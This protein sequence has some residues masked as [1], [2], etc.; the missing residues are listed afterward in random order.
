MEA[1]IL[2]MQID[3]QWIKDEQ[4][5]T[6]LL[7]GVNLGG[8]SKL[9]TTPDGRTFNRERFYDHRSVS[10]VGRPF[11]LSA[12]D[13]HFA[14]LRAWGMTFVRFL[15]TW[16]AVEHAGPGVYDRDYL[17]YLRAVISKAAE[18]D[19]A[20]YIDPHQD[21]WSRW[22]GGDGAP[23]WT[24][25]AIGFDLTQLDTTGA[26]I[27]HAGHGDPF[28][29]MIWPTNY[30]KLGAAT[31]FALFY[32]GDDLA[33][34]TRINGEPAQAYLQRHYIAAMQQVALALKGLPNVVGYGAMN[35]PV[36]SLLGLADVRQLPTRNLIMTG[37]MPNFWQAIQLGVGYAQPVGVYQM[38]FSGP[39]QLDTVTLNP[40]GKR[41][42]RDGYPCVW[43]QNGVWEPDADGQPQLLRPDYFAQ[44]NGRTP[45]FAN[46]YLKPFIV[47]YIQALREVDPHTILFVEG[48][49]GGEH[50]HW[51][52]GDPPNIVNAAH[53]YDA[54]TLFMKTFNP[55]FTVDFNT[56]LPIMGAD[57]VAQST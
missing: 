40:D 43:Q 33:P 25:E 37:A 57:A 27:T 6:L 51:G 50:P 24:L 18:H 20:C 11:P 34:H 1:S 3:G 38:G 30:A 42:W 23:G 47:R 32:A 2:P 12:A 46:D 19:I 26:A 55:E 21:V 36:A 53:W 41:V 44:V 29:R 17:D 8:S 45:D 56:Q 49:P 13:A 48:V 9:P 39:E 54:L 16:E 28:P 52:A 5:R 7:R 15:V 31:M 35:E 10:F 14:R 4:G 22:T